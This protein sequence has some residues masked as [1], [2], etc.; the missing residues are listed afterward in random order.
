MPEE[1]AFFGRTAGYGVLIA[2]AYWFVSYE[3]TG[4]VLL[5]GFGLATGVGFVL[6]WRRSRSAKRTGAVDVDRPFTDE[7][8]PVPL[9]SFAPLELGLGIAVVGLGLV[10]GIWFVIAAAVPVAVGALEWVREARHELD[11]VS[12]RAPSGST[13]SPGAGRG[14]AD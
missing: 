13:A 4:T 8:G 9:R 11:L 12:T 7:S 3:V 2:I 10:F 6:L 1:V 14:P 5:A